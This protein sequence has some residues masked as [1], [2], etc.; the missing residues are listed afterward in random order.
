MRECIIPR[1]SELLSPYGHFNAV[2]VADVRNLD[3]TNGKNIL[4]VMIIT[5]AKMNID[6]ALL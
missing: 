2:V 6:P 4:A 3:I 1:A 5:S